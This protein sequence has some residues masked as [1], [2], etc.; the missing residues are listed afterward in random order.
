MGGVGGMALTRRWAAQI[1]ADGVVVV[2]AARRVWERLDADRNRD[3]HVPLSIA[4]VLVLYRLGDV[5]VVLGYYRQVGPWVKTESMVVDF[6]R[7]GC[8]SVLSR[9]RKLNRT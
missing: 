6:M 5:L 8:D 2:E 3:R 4:L 1:G 7:C 9:H